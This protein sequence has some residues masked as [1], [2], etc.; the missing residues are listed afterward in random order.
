MMPPDAY[1]IPSWALA[2][3]FWRK[4][5][6]VELLEGAK[7]ADRH[8]FAAVWTP[9]RHFHEFGG[10]YPNPSVTSA[11]I[12]MVT[13]TIQIRSGSVV[14]PLHTPIRIAEEWSVVDNLSNGPVAISFASGRMPEDVVR[15]PDNYATRKD[16]MLRS[17]ETV[18]KL[19]RGEAIALPS[20]LGRGVQVR[21][22]P[23][24]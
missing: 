16:V 5:L 2:I 24:P 3:L 23:P 10:L 21:M 11:A 19:W 4:V 22:L 13:K 20:P 7:F 9:E 8:G 1:D 18:R 15:E 17:I 12:A 14:A 6:A